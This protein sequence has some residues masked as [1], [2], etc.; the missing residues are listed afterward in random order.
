[1]EDFFKNLPKMTNNHLHIYGM[2]PYR[3]LL[4]LIKVIDP[5]LYSKIYVYNKPTE[6]E[7]TTQPVKTVIQDKAMTI[8]D[9]N[10]EGV[11][12][13]E[14][15]KQEN[16]KSLTEYD[17]EDGDYT[18]HLYI[19]A[20][21]P[22]ANYVYN[23]LQTRF[24]TLV[25]NYRVYYYLWYTTLFVNRNNE[26]YY[27]NVRGKPGTINTG[28]KFGQR[29]YLESKHIMNQDTF[30]KAL[31]TLSQT[32][33]DIKE[34]DYKFMYSLYSKIKLE[35]DLIVKAVSSINKSSI[36]P[37]FVSDSFLLDSAPSYK[38]G[39]QWKTGTKPQSMVQYIITFSKQPKNLEVDV[40]QYTILIKQQ[41]YIAAIINQEYKFQF[42]NGVD[43]VGNEQESHDLE[44]YATLV[45]KIMYF[46][47]FGLNFIPHVG[48]TNEIRSEL[49]LSE[50][51]VFEKNLSRIGHG[52]AF[53]TTKESLDHLEAKKK[54]L[55]VESC[56]I[57]NYLLGYYSP[58]VHP[59]KD[60][61]DSPYIK[62]MIC[63]DTN[64]IFNYSSVT[65]DYIFV[66][67][68]W[69]L[70][71]SDL[72]NL[73][74][75]GLYPIPNEYRAYYSSYFHY[76]WDTGAYDKQKLDF[77]AKKEPNANAGNVYEQ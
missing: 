27:L 68:Y 69:M 8:I 38:F 43:L 19:D 2:V 9:D 45:N 35:S 13:E 54:I 26:V 14:V 72:K 40:R 16:W 31:K 25:R 6:T 28:T 17:K 36:Y 20:E 41:L 63:S 29:L 75:N 22:R 48:E 47:K 1:M 73:I 62:L 66:A 12:Y 65:R 49:T 64:G 15:T 42:F 56:P 57:S 3:K 24:R 67:R 76:V 60:F 39:T 37:E 55:Y 77:W 32:D 18:K 51:L 30:S 5:V 23:N 74:L 71:M 61:V 46:R 34:S 10:V 50:R 7:A 59:H 44:Y 58:Q 4:N 21:T 70:K 11:A 53:T 33:H 52:I